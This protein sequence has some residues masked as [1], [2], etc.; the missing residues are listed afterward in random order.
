MKGSTGEGCRADETEV[1]FDYE[2]F[3]EFTGKQK[4]ESLCFGK[5][6]V[7]VECSGKCK[8]EQGA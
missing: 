6:D 2:I 8:V 4:S 1:G 3:M 5:V 7:V